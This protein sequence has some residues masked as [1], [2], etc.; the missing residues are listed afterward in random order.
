MAITIDWPSGVINVPRTD[1]TLVQASPEIRELDLDAFWRTLRS[2]EDGEAGRPFPLVVEYSSPTTFGNT[3]LA[4]VLV[5]NDGYYSV[6]FEDAQY[7]VE[8]VGMNSNVGF[9]TNVNQVSVRSNNSAGLVI[10]GSGLTAEQD[11][12][13]TRI[14]D[15]GG[16]NEERVGDTWRR[17][18]KDTD[19]IIDSKDFTGDIDGDWTLTETP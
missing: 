2:L 10:T 5:I 14:D 13:L 6:T 11:T 18:H 12:K 4:A 8:L 1:M 3:P 19:V 16:A 15:R 9:V 7:A 17:R